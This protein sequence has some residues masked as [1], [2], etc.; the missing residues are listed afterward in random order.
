MTYLATKLSFH[1]MFLQCC[2]EHL[3]NPRE[4]TTMCVLFLQQNSRPASIQCHFPVSS[5]GTWVNRMTIVYVLNGLCGWHSRLPQ[6]HGIVLCTLVGFIPI[7]KA[8]RTRSSLFFS[9][10]LFSSLVVCSPLQP[11]SLI[12]SSPLDLLLLSSLLSSSCIFTLFRSSEWL[13]N[14]SH[15][16]RHSLQSNHFRAKP[17]LNPSF[18]LEGI[19]MLNN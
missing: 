16:H 19:W 4:G 15:P 8:K 3:K 14:P 7:Q 12:P 5:V 13:S 10:P 1:Q 9:F 17:I 11:S 2:E 18:N 6:H